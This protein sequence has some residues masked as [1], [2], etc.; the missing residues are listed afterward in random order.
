MAKEVIKKPRIY[1]MAPYIKSVLEFLAQRQDH[2][3]GRGG[4]RDKEIA[5][6]TTV[7][8]LELIRGE[9]N[10]KLR[11]KEPFQPK[12]LERIF[13]HL[14]KEGFLKPAKGERERF[15]VSAR[16]YKLLSLKRAVPGQAPQEVGEP[17]TEKEKK[18]KKG[19]KVRG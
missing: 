17:K 14:K 19:R 10:K 8:K 4:K 15:I 1:T 11:P 6:G 18:G 2:F 5:F 7:K 12:S 9:I 13:Q 16:A 3:F